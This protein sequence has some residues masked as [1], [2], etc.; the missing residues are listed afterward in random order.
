MGKFGVSARREAEGGI[1]IAEGGLDGG[2]ELRGVEEAANIGLGEMGY[3]LS[4]I[5]MSVIRRLLI[6]R[7][8]G[9]PNVVVNSI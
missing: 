1:A 5:R 2:A 7:I 3:R 8:V 9:R 6:G 4:V